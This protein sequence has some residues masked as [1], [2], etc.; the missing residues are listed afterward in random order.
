MLALN[1]KE[2]DRIPIDLGG[3]IVSSIAKS[4]Y[5]T[6]KQYGTKYQVIASITTVMAEG[7]LVDT[8][9]GTLLWAGK[10][11]AQDNSGG[12]G[13][14]FVDLV[15]AVVGQAINQPA[16]HAH[17]VARM[18]NGQLGIKDHGLLYGPYH[19]KYGQE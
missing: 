7:R 13:N 12:S 19:P 3:T 4:S 1:H 18:A 16:D 2:P 6:L 15:A 10:V 9:T 5:I 8:R 17:A 14:V 11:M